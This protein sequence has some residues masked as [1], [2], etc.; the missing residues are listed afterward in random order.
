MEAVKPV[1][2][3]IYFLL[4]GRNFISSE[5][6]IGRLFFSRSR[7]FVVL[8]QLLSVTRKVDKRVDHSLFLSLLMADLIFSFIVDKTDFL[9]AATVCGEHFAV[10]SKA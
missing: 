3:D 8:Q 10:L 7:I 2:N 1:G 6:N 9:F 4:T 5:L